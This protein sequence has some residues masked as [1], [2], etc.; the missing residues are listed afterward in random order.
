M[1][2]LQLRDARE[3]DFRGKLQPK[4]LALLIYLAHPP[5]RFHRRDSL[6]ALFWP[7]LDSGGA[8]NSLRQ[9]LYELRRTLGKGILTGRGYEEVAV[10]E[11]FLWS[12]VVAFEFALEKDQMERAL[13]LYRGDLLEGFHVQNVAPEFEH[14]LEAERV[15]LRNRAVRASLA[16]SDREEA[17]GD[18]AR[19]AQWTQ[20]AARFDPDNESVLRRL[21]DLL[22][23]AG[24]R[25][26]AVRVF[27][28]FARRTR[29]EYDIEPSE[30]TRTLI[31]A[32]RARTEPQ[33]PS[34]TPEPGI[35][36]P[37]TTFIGREREL[38]A[39]ERL[40]LDPTT[41]LV[42][43]TG[44]GGSGK[45][46]L[47]LQFARRMEEHFEDGIIIIAVGD[48]PDAEEVLS[49]IAQRL[50]L[51][52]NNLQRPLEAAQRYLEQREMLLVLDEFEH[53]RAAG[54]QII[55]LLQVA[56]RLKVLTTSRAPLKVSSEREFSVPPLSLPEPGL[57]ATVEFP[58]NSEAVAL[59][60]ARGRGV[61]PDFQLT[62]KNVEAVSEICCRLDGIP[63]AIEL[64]AA[65]VK[66]LT[67]EAI[68]K[69]VEERFAF[70][71]DGPTDQPLRHQSLEGAISWSY[72]LLDE[73]ER[74]LFRRLGVFAGGFGLELAEMLFETDGYSALELIDGLAALVDYGLVS[75]L[76]IAGEPRFVMLDT[77]HAY[78][79]KLL[80]ESGEEDAWRGRHAKHLVAWAED[81]EQYY[82]THEQDFWFQR[83]E[84]EHENV[85][86][87]L[88]WVLDHRE[89]SIAVR[90]GA[91]L[92]P[93]WYLSGYL[94]QARP[95][96][97]RIL[98]TKGRAPRIARAKALIGASWMASGAAEHARAVEYAKKGAELY[99][100]AGDL[101]GQIRALET[102]GF[103]RL[104]A[105]E[106]ERAQSAFEECLTKSQALGDERRQSI[107]LDALGQVALA[108]GDDLSAESLFRRSVSLAR[109]IGHPIA[110]GQGLWCLGDV[111][112]RSGA[113]D[114]ATNFYED[115]LTIYREAGQK[116]NIAWTLSCLGRALVESGR[117]RTARES[118]G[119][120]LR[121]F[122]ELGYARGMAHTLSG[123]AAIALAQ[124][125]T[126][127]AAK[128]LGGTESLLECADDHFSPYDA[129]AFAALQ[130]ATQER[131]RKPKFN[132]R[133]AEGRQLDA[134]KLVALAVAG[135][136]AVEHRALG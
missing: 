33:E 121:L 133:W 78:A 107:A 64:A 118:Y 99:H 16:L 35:L 105:G 72:E 77:V 80:A 23:R 120:A 82:C 40:L 12:D 34:P 61:R 20:T 76:E 21:V 50:G 44:L 1:G 27:N 15:R 6:M 53:V 81:G 5:R 60:I 54:P 30:E 3:R 127:G 90:L 102:L 49:R 4:R 101:S 75:Q 38:V 69:R 86:V 14:W 36:E 129:A 128:L 93:F 136:S 17:L 92:W 111:A 112:R 74:T 68:A 115:A 48:A 114:R 19:A 103:V 25:V 119:E 126:E 131:L 52:E 10:V 24:D 9:S 63:L 29:E 87:A 55:R 51:R 57:K 70:L 66:A 94:V 56:P 7:E 89:A 122:Q 104:E 26:G 58:L 98:G 37:P 88:R 8:R 117:I 45:T 46:R 96:L 47:A 32:M 79:Q 113:L 85:R 84:R 39:L 67:P 62:A 135:E 125:D 83:L 91:A 73:V 31:D 106:V 100:A 124:G 65:R 97:E 71:R 28:A 134:N 11:R 59:F 41:R 132:A 110:V 123:F 116:I 42:T 43:L 130:F 13:A 18:L 2:A 22:D 108:R 109:R 95:W